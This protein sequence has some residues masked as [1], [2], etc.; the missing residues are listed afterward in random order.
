MPAI[1]AW[2]DTSCN[3]TKGRRLVSIRQTS[4]SSRQNGNG[5]VHFR[6]YIGENSPL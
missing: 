2:C 3:G 5:I 6:G 1:E 4:G